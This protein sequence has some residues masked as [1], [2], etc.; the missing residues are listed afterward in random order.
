MFDAVID[1]FLRLVREFKARQRGERTDW[2]KESWNPS[3]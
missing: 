3:K 1:A 2:H